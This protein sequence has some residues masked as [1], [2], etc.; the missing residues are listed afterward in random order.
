[1]PSSPV[2]CKF[3]FSKETV[4][5][6]IGFTRKSRS[7]RAQPSA[8]MQHQK[9]LYNWCLTLFSALLLLAYTP[10][11]ATQSQQEQYD[12]LKTCEVFVVQSRWHTGI[13]LKTAEA[14]T[15]F[16]PEIVQYQ[17]RRFIDIGWGDERFY[18][19][20]GSPLFLAARAV[21]WPTQSILEIDTFNSDIQRVYGKNARLIR[22]PVT[23]TQFNELC[24]FIANSYQRDEQGSP[25]LSTLY[26]S[27][28][29]FYLATRKYH[30]FRTCNTWI[31]LAFKK[32]GFQV[33]SCG[34][35]NANQ[36]FRQLKKIQGAT[37]E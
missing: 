22:I 8:I 26:A 11:S 31:A 2:G 13:I 24:R 34:V 6:I 29:R 4:C 7:G 5:S 33:R 36:L 19:A 15:G 20:Q 9:V 35:L 18:Q 32:A 30:L 3:A 21:M 12:T 16:W 37:F 28:T 14:D 27:N 10:I 23:K 25:Q 1:M 17:N